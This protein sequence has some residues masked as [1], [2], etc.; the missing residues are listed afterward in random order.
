MND[1]L[2]K[3]QRYGRSAKGKARD[4]RY[5]STQK[6]RDVYATYNASTQG[7]VRRL[8]HELSV[9]KETA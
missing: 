6:K 3:D 4:A 8:R 7:I 1:G 2:T 9:A 5:Q